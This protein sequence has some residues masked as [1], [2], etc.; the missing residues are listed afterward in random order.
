MF[1][2]D[3]C[4]LNM[5]LK[6][7]DFFIGVIDF[8]SVILPGALGAF[9]LKGLLYSNLF[10][11]GKVFPL[12]ETEVQG[13]IV[14]LFATYIIGNMIFP[15]GALLL[16]RFVYDKFLRKFL[17][18]KENDPSYRAA[19]AIRDQYIPSAARED[20]R[21]VINTF[22][23]AQH[24]L[25][26][27]FPETLADIRKLEAD[28]KFFRSLVIAFIIIG[29]VLIG[30]TEWISGTC[31]LAVSL[32]SLYR[33]GDLRYKSTEKAYE[34]IITITHQEKGSLTETVAQVQERQSHS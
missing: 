27:K 14:F 21:E 4:E 31:F 6:P 9:F 20:K 8:F 33:Y 24:F 5:N 7:S 32:L 18:K 2:L 16:D 15:I 25:A 28:S 12:P 30:K 26:I 10:G 1:I 23:W 3:R 19:T 13:W 29:A 17:F 11:D 22:K 34:L